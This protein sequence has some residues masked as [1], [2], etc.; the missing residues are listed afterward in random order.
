MST[1]WS[2]LVMNI[3]V[4]NGEGDRCQAYKDLCASTLLLHLWSLAE[5][6]LAPPID[7]IHRLRDLVKTYNPEAYESIVKPAVA[8]RYE[9]EKDRIKAE[10][11]LLK[12][13][14]QV[15]D[16]KQRAESAAATATCSC[17]LYQ[18]CDICKKF[19]PR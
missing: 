15:N 3:A 13:T 5:H 9:A 8:K 17:G 2:D 6:R 10:V 11:A 19:Q 16:R 7:N 14:C 18:T 1:N 12:W 4:L